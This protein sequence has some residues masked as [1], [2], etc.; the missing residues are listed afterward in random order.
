MA[1]L[2]KKEIRKRKRTALKELGH[3]PDHVLRDRLS[4]QGGNGKLPKT[5]KKSGNISNQKGAFGQPGWKRG[6][7]SGIHET[8]STTNHVRCVGSRKRAEARRSGNSSIVKAL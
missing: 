2:S 5:G 7:T 4:L 3:N 6:L 1:N 8:F